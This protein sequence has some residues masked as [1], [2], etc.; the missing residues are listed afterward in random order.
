MEYNNTA[1]QEKRR[2]FSGAMRMSR[3]DMG[4]A[5]VLAAALL[6]SG[7][8]SSEPDPAASGGATSV[9]P[10]SGAPARPDMV[11]AV[12]ASKTPGA[13]DLRFA[14]SARP[15]VGQPLDIEFL[16][17]PTRELDA[18][19]ARFQAG[20]GLELVKGAETERLEHPAIGTP[21]P[22]VVTVIPRGDGIFYVTAVIVSDSPTES[23][24]RNYAIPIIA[25][26][27]LAE[28]PET[29]APRPESARAQP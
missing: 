26:T 4:A 19:L 15:T 18:L 1:A 14:V 22:H 13:V 11:A 3:R 2:G 20:E 7:C 8:G 24:S 27:G 6:C 23:V 12:S 21:L 10:K 28:L 29:A 5:L 17:T 25:G 9:R 16:L